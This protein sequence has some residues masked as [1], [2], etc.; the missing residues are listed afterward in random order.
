M[1]LRRPFLAL[2]VSAV[3]ASA[4]LAPWE[5]A[6]QDVADPVD[7][8]EDQALREEAAAKF[9]EALQTFQRAFDACLDEAAKGGDVRRSNLAR[10]EVLLEKV[11]SLAET[12]TKQSATEEFLAKATTERAGPLLKGHVD[13]ERA[14]FRMARGD[15]EGAKSLAAGLGF[16]RDWWILGPFDNE[17]G[18]K[19][20]P[21]HEVERKR[22][23]FD[24]EMQGKERKVR[25]RK[26]PV[27]PEFG[28]VDLDALLRPNDQ[29]F[30]FAVAFV[31]SGAA[32]DA[33]L[34]IGSDEAL[35]VWWNGK[36]VVSRDVRRELGFD[37]DVAAV[38]LVP[39]WNALLVKCHDQTGAWAF[40]A[41]LTAP[42]GAPL[43]GGVEWAETDAAAREAART[44]FEP[45]DAVTA[46]D[47][48]AKA[49]YDQA[50][51][52][53]ST[54]PRDLF[55]LGYLHATRDFDSFADRKAENL[56]KKAA[57]ADPSNAVYRFHYA[58]A[59]APPAELAVE[60]EENR[61]RIG[62]EKAIELDSR[63]AVAYRALAS[64]YTGSLLNLERAEDLL[65]KAL[66]V[67]PS[68]VEAR[69]DLSQVLA[70]RGLSAQSQIERARALEDARSASLE[71]AA[72]ARAAAVEGKGMAREAMDAW[73]EVLR[74]DARGSDVR[75]RVAELAAAALER[76]EALKVLAAITEQN[77]Y[78]LAARTR[79]AEI[80]EGAD[81]FDGATKALEAA[82]EVAPEDDG[83]LQS[84]G[85]V[86]AKAGR[87]K[88]AIATLRKALEV[89]PK[90]QPVERYVE[91]LD[92]DAAPYEDDWVVSDEALKPLLD[93]AAAWDNQENDATIS[94][95]DQVVTKVNRDGTS[96][97]YTRQ[98][99]R[100]LTEAGVKELD[101]VWA[102]GWGQLKWKWAR[103]RKPD[104]AVIEAKIQGQMAD[105][106]PLRP[107]DVVD[108]A[109]RRDDREQGY[110]GDY[111][112]D[113]QYFAAYTPV[114]RS[115]YTLIT[116]AERT[117]YFH[118]KNFD[119]KPEVAESEKD[120]RRFRTYTWRNEDVAKVKFEQGMP[121]QRENFPQ[122]QV[123]TYKDWDQFATW[124]ASMIRD[125]RILTDEMKAKV[126]ELT[127][128]K[129]SRYEK[130]RAIYDFVTG[131][132]TYQ[133]WPFGEHGY[134]PYTTTQI[135][136]KREG[137]CKDKALLLC[138]LLPEI[139][140]ECHPV[141]IYADVG[142]SEEDLTLPMIGE[143]N[144]CIAY[145]PDS[146]GKGT[147]IFVDGTAQYHSMAS[148]PMMDRGAKVLIVKPDGGEIA[149]IPIGT[150]D[151]LGLEQD[152]TF[153]VRPDGSA[154]AK[155]KVRWLGDFA[156]Q[157]RSGFSV[158]GQ[159]GTALQQMFSGI[160]GK[161][162]LQHFEFADLK[163]LS[164][165]E[166]SFEVTLELPAFA[167]KSGEDFVLPT[168]YLEQM[169]GA[170]LVQSVQRPAR[171]H[172]LILVNP[173]GATTRAT[174]V[175]PEGWTVAS[176]PEDADVRTPVGGFTSKTTVEGTTLKLERSLATTAAR[177]KKDDYQAFREGV[178]RTVAL[179]RQT[180]KVTP[181]AAPAGDGAAPP[182]A[183]QGETPK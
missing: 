117:F 159:R 66:E 170:I 149:Q 127:K 13:W 173:L 112:G 53:E 111:F 174:F 42:D 129:E 19:F 145:I 136:E 73:S 98:V 34:R 107:G 25:W 157:I 17:R 175:L 87:S 29:A 57:E 110:F 108:V 75:R 126:A 156:T 180:F 143:F 183:P 51:A 181:G 115:E 178:T 147:P 77:P 49:W 158:E 134:K 64:Y 166:A 3:L 154:T 40:R 109:W 118:Q 96:S 1:T 141:L 86:H 85:R 78:D 76:D 48:G 18:S 8:I 54:K 12:T 61:Q 103:V 146:D 137:D 82:L 62:R 125:N 101:R 83:L 122:V 71:T 161:L 47:A 59:A 15:R 2:T 65:R 105:P 163:D 100:V 150:R 11:R 38:R 171:E 128:D 68:Y 43:A 27:R 84:L 140:V 179:S 24:D 142:R 92:P 37:Q 36:P 23:D 7:P 90:L 32:L 9:D 116:P 135:F 124:W 165:P 81:D 20:K 123:T 56:L 16:V 33:A 93:K 182:S 28:L 169:I 46:A 67:N 153:T 39:G 63:Y 72:R 114:L 138:T 21:P 55:H 151:D 119:A 22:I 69:L 52:G 130:I 45:A 121:E 167:K 131:E 102:R 4:P 94:V 74:L 177:V 60:K 26:N 41:R 99:S 139:G 144:H 106:P 91:F 58:E 14:K 133:A 50:T 155:G 5:A 152:W 97:T 35:K 176:K 89:N 95:L 6:A 31:K 164:K 168:S 172:D 30:A 148:P 162:D 160:F 70:R 104:G 10:A 80:L 113:W 120:G 44:E 88:E 132:I 79:A